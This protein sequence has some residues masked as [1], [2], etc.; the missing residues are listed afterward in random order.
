M[1]G[2]NPFLS[3]PN[4]NKVKKCLAAMDFLVVQDIFLTETAAYADVILPGTSFPEKTGTYTN[5][6][7][8]V[9]LARKAVEPPGQCRVDWHIVADLAGRMGYPMPYTSE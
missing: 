6:D 9:Q 4:I 1:M 2:E 7:S 5:T 3:D 8:R